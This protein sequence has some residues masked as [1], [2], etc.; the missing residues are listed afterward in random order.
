M[1][2][3]PRVGVAAL[4]ALYPRDSGVGNMW[5]HVLREL[6]I[7]YDL[8]SLE[9]GSVRSRLWRPR[10]WVQDGHQG[11][12]AVREP[13]VAQLHEAAWTD[14]ETRA[15]LEPEFIAMYEERSRAGARAAARIVTPSAS[16]RDQ[17]V[18]AYGVDAARVVVAPHGVDHAT[19]RPDV[20][21]ADSVLTR[22]GAD[23]AR[24]YV[25]FVSQLHPRKNLGAL[26]TAMARLVA[27]GLPHQLV[28]V[29]RPA[30][31]RPAAESQELIGDLPGTTGRVVHL[32]G[33]DDA[34]LAAVMAGAAAFC[35]PSFMEG[36]GLTA[37]EAMA[38]AT[39][40]VVSDRGALPEVVGEAGVVVEPTADAVEAA[41]AGV[42]G[43]PVRADTL[44]R[45]GLARSRAFTWE[46]T[47]RQWS[48]A[49]D[50]AVRSG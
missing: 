33:I 27:E 47:A 8:R 2:R 12:L 15:V 3:R 45:A 28:I 18:A 17:I 36:F 21:G 43:D 6:A 35:L 50:E 31:D 20:A 38:C 26:R 5:H 32:E 29:G 34:D 24:P 13:V 22:A 25:L 14:P 1:S 44:A 41:L 46:A 42:L 16:S 9:P 30:M 39:P 4:I 7:G 23:A 11:A 19:F 48:R 40:V 10:S 37:L 49:I